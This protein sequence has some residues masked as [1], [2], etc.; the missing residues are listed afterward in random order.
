MAHCKRWVR[1]VTVSCRGR[2][3]QVGCAILA[4]LSLT[5]AANSVIFVSK[6]NGV[7]IHRIEFYSSVVAY[8]VIFASRDKSFP[9]SLGVYLIYRGIFALNLALLFT[10]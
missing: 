1:I 7:K 10:T 9:A 4:N 6:T 5:L 2:F 3:P 8:L